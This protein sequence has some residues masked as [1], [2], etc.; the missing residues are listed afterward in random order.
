MF[1]TLIAIVI[2]VSAVGYFLGAILLSK[3]LRSGIENLWYASAKQLETSTPH[4]LFDM[5]DRIIEVIYR[6]NGRLSIYKIFT[7]ALFGTE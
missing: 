5:A 6:T 4:Q 3:S 7:V 1:S 2:F